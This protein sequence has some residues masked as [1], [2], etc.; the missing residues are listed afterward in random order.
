[1][2]LPR[3]LWISCPRPRPGARLRL[4]CFPY[5]GGGPQVF[6]TW[7]DKLPDLVEVC[8]LHYPGR[9]TRLGEPL[10]H[11]AHALA[12]AITEA[13]APQLDKPF[14]F[15]G[16]SLGVPLSFDVARLLRARGGPLPLHLILSG[17]NALHLPMVEEPIHQLPDEEFIA[18]VR[19]L[20]GT[21]EDLLRHKEMMAL[22]LPVLRADFEMAATYAYVHEPPLPCPITALGGL[23]D[24]STSRE[25]LEAWAAQT[26]A[27]FSL[28]MFPGNHFF[29]HTDEPS[30][31]WALGQI[32]YKTIFP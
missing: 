7:S 30:L 10:F 6:R 28:R 26:T 22:M 16:H 4:F 27:A 11:R 24:R 32:L 20:A 2:A 25:G 12:E 14:A 13:I 19:A 5:S 31:L 17:Y 3:N 9:S 29:L 18:R 21:P 15:F 1:M 23:Q 8:A